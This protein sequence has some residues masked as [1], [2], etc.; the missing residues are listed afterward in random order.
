MNLIKRMV[1]LAAFTSMLL[2]LFG[3]V[4]APVAQLNTNTGK[5]EVIIAS[6]KD[7]IIA[8]L[9][10]RMLSGDFMIRMQAENVIAFSRSSVEGSTWKDELRRGECRVIFNLVEAQG[11]IL[12]M[13]KVLIIRNPN[14]PIE[15]VFADRSTGS[16]E[17]QSLQG[18][19]ASIKTDLES[20]PVAKAENTFTLTNVGAVFGAD[21]TTVRVV[22]P[23]GPADIAGLKVGDV[24]TAIDRAPLGGVPLDNAKRIAVMPGATVELQ[25]QRGG[26]T[27]TLPILG[28]DK[29]ASGWP[30]AKPSAPATES[31]ATTDQAQVFVVE[32]LGIITR[33]NVITSLIADG[34]AHAAGVKKGDVLVMI[35]DE[36]V[37][38]RIA[39]SFAKLRGRTNSPVALTLKRENQI[40]TVPVVRK[41]QP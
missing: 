24:V 22:E 21:C 13:T 19:L 7:A 16:I 17:A 28:L 35:D 25:I 12:V 30:V 27:L 41:V 2:V 15:S 20:A 37:S 38:S 23:N 29:P 3:C 33:E 31:P 39:E 14:T 6:T 8:G 40:V 9:T 34:P 10:R 26:Q 18:L 36:I 1:G 11:G 4:A 5:P 32:E